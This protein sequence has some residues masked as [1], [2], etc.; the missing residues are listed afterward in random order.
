MGSTLRRTALH[1]LSLAG[2]LLLLAAA[3][4]AF[5]CEK[6]ARAQ[7]CRTVMSS[8]LPEEEKLLAV[9]SMIDQ[10]R[11]WNIAVE[12]AGPPE[13]TRVVN[14][15]LVRNAW[16]RIMAVVPSVYEG[17]VLLT[18]GS[19]EV[20]ALSGFEVRTPSGT[21]R[22][23]CRTTYS[24]RH[25]SRTAV[26]V[27]GVSLGGGK[28]VRYIADRDMAFRAELVVSTEL[29]VRHYRWTRVRDRLV[30]SYARTEVRRG[31]TATSDALQAR[32]YRPVLKPALRVV[33]QYYG[34][35]QVRASVPNASWY[36]IDFGNGAY[37]EEHHATLEP[38]LAP[39]PYYI[40]N[41]RVSN[42][43]GSAYRAIRQADG[44]IYV[45]G[46]KD[47]KVTV[48]DY[49][50]NQTLP[51]NLRFT[52]ANLTIA[53][54]KTIY[55]AGEPITVTIAPSGR[56]AEISY[57]NLTLNATG[58][59]VF[60]AQSGASLITA[61]SDGIETYRVVSV[62]TGAWSTAIRIVLGFIA[63]YIVWRVLVRLLGGAYDL[64]HS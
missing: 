56:R 52:P 10:P 9:A 27:N 22:G 62:E 50:R 60:K 5:P 23:D 6:L 16:I 20:V 13:G 17:S 11:D 42:A 30:C 4:Q 21:E 53:T 12:P 63:V 46:V 35:T 2:L 36:R 40:L 58:R 39:P 54:D 49:F 32:L 61:R 18:P 57:A 28:V 25:S 51:C 37:Y 43:S 38:F 8:P 45:S 41:F 55:K 47:C 7:D 26:S 34:I 64:W 29:T 59:A 15:E 19:G 14:T 44:S 33:N 48:G 3:A 24:L 1:G 31:N